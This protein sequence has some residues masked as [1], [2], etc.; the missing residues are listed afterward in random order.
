MPS[1]SNFK[2]AEYFRKR[3][4]ESRT[5]AEQMLDAHTKS[6]MLD[7]AKSYEEIVK[8]YEKIASWQK[9]TRESK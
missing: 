3:A 7:I 5:L 2:D 6:L 8:S 4:E 1:S 9:G